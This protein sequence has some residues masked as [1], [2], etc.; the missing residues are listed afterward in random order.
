MEG[1]AVEGPVIC[2][3][4]EEELQALNEVKTGKTPGQS[5]VSLQLIATSGGSGNSSNG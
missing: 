4:R 1:D 2:V 3:S 5:E